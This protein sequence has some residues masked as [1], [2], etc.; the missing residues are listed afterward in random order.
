MLSSKGSPAGVLKAWRAGRFEVVVSPRLLAE[1][2][3]ALAY[4]KLSSRI[5]EVQ[6]GQL[7]TWVSQ[8]GIN[9]DDP[10]HHLA[11]H[12]HDPGDDY[13]IALAAAHNAAL[14]SGDNHVLELKSKIPVYTSSDFLKLIEAE[15]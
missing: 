7:V 1:L 11:I 13:L 5:T 2:R 10:E 3:R 4:P 15:T 12:S 14:V 8:L 9:V 6:A